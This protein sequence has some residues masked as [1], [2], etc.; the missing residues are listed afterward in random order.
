[1]RR[2]IF[3]TLRRGVDNALANWQLSLIRFLEVFVF[4]AIM[5]GAV[6]AIVAPILLTVGIRLMDLADVNDFES[7]IL[8]LGQKWIILL[9]IFVV[10]AVLFLV[11]M[12]VHSF[13]EAGCAR[14][15]VDAERIAGPATTG[16]RDRFRIF[17]TERWLAG[18]KDGWWEVFWIYNIAWGLGGLVLLIPAIP[19]IAL[20]LAFRENEGAA[21][22]MGCLG[23]LAIMMLMFVV[24][25]VIGMW[26][27]RAIADW[28]ARRA[29]IRES[30][31][32]G[33]QA[34]KNDLARHLLIM[35][36]IMVV[37]FAGSTFFSSFSFIAAFG[38]A[39][40]SNNAMVNVITIPIRVIAWLFSTAFSALISSW[41]L[42]SYSA[43]AVEGRS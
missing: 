33:W 41:Y 22:A 42:A 20:M 14:V 40:G 4:I 24:A 43:L 38:E 16:P 32:A 23:L 13:V 36:A 7:A 27:N 3:D 19:T 37:A 6:F 34:V 25:I 18:G 17:S 28:A 26:G 30:L 1:M 15:L 39:F 29:G 10:L 12:A 8:A 2:G 11:F 5:I 35:L 31:A 21:V 9:W